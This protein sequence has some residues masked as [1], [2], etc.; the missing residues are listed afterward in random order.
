MQSFILYQMNEVLMSFDSLQYMM[1]VP[2]KL[3]HTSGV[4]GLSCLPQLTQLQYCQS[5]CLKAGENK[6]GNMSDR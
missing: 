5:G 1:N 4:S 3:I 2:E 6:Q